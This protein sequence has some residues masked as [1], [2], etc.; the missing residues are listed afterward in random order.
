MIESNFIKMLEDDY[1]FV[2]NKNYE[3]TYYKELNEKMAEELKIENVKGSIEKYIKELN[4]Y[5]EIKDIVDAMV[6]KIAEYRGI[7]IV[8]MREEL[9]LDI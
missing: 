4:T 5:N 1:Y 8:E 7:S 6:G 2:I 9:E 3:I